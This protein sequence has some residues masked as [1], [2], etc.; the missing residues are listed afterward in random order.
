MIGWIAVAI[1]G[2]DNIEDVVRC[3]AAVSRSRW[4]DFEI[5]ICENGGT[6]AAYRLL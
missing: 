1:V 4:R 6:S 2:Y 3:V 5:C